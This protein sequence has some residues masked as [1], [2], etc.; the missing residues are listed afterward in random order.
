[1]QLGNLSIQSSMW[2]CGN[3]GWNTHGDSM[4]CPRFYQLSPFRLPSFPKY[5]KLEQG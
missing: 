3:Y 5:F 2:V 1:M 4:L